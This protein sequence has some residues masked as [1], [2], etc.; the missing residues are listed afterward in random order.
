MKRSVADSARF[1]AFRLVESALLGRLGDCLRVASG[2]QRTGIA[3]QPVCGA[4]Y[5]ELSIAET[6]RSAVRA[7]QNESSVFKKLRIWPARQAQLKS[8]LRRL[9]AGDLGDSFRSLA[10]IDQQSKGRAA[11]D[12]WRT[13]DRL[14]WALCEPG[15]VRVV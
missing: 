8:A 10:L 5:R 6:V 2:L 15:R 4:L 1:D 11:G 14:L 13:L 9:D 7:G 3:I 12:P